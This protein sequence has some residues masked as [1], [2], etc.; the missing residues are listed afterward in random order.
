M[1]ASEP[2]KQALSA[3][4]EKFHSGQFIAYHLNNGSGMQFLPN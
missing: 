4:S 3:Q 2:Q 1:E